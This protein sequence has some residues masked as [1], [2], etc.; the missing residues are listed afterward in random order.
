M[1]FALRCMVVSFSFNFCS[2]CLPWFSRI[3][4]YF[5]SLLVERWWWDEE[6]TSEDDE[7]RS[8]P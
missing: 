5:V 8:T 6:T 4:F 2:R 3:S 1:S 7:E